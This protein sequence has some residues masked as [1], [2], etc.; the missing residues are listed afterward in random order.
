MAATAARSSGARWRRSAS[1]ASTA[2]HQSAG[3]CSDHSGC[4]RCTLSSLRAVATS[5]CAEST[6]TAFSSEVPRSMPRYTGVMM[7]AATIALPAGCTIAPTLS[8]CP[9]RQGV[10]RRG[11]PAVRGDKKN[12]VE[13]KRKLAERSNGG[14]PSDP[15]E[16][17]QARVAWYYY[18]GNLTQQQI[19]TRIGSNRV[20]VNRLLAAG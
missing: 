19:A 11:P 10:E 20:R 8:Q 13:G 6:S 16:E 15:E 4:G 9:H 17:L 12:P 14:G 5:R 7:A 1:A 3:C 2:C 18:V